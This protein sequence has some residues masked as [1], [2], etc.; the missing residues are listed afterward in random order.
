LTARCADAICFIIIHA[1]LTA[2]LPENSS[3]L[4]ERTRRDHSASSSK[5]SDLAAKTRLQVDHLRDSFVLRGAA[6]LFISREEAGRVRE[7]AVRR[8]SPPSIT[9]A[10]SA[11]VCSSAMAFPRPRAASFAVAATA[12]RHSSINETT[13]RQMELS[14]VLDYVIENVARAHPSLRSASHLGSVLDRMRL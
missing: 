1:T 14:V 4:T 9:I 13:S 12:K 2:Q 7:K 3:E 6:N 11:A 10:I 8:Y 5:D